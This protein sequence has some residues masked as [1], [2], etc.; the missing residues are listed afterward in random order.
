MIDR[1]NE[2]LG[3]NTSLMF[4]QHQFINWLGICDPVTLQKKRLKIFQGSL[5]MAIAPYKDFD[6]I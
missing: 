1:L 4:F 2:V 3:Q 6:R 5:K